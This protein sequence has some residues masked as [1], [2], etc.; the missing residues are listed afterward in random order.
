[1][2]GIAIALLKKFWP[3]MV[4]FALGAI[5]VGGLTW[6]IQGLRVTA[7]QQ[8]TTRVQQAFDKFALDTYNT[9]LKAEAKRLE[10]EQ[11]AKDNLK[12]VQADHEKQI[13]SI[14]A[15]AVD[16]Y[17]AAHR[18]RNDAGANSGGGTVQGDGASHQMD[19]GAAKECVP[20]EG[21]IAD[22]A[23]DAEKVQA[24]RAYC[25][26]NNCPIE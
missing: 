11:K 23:E 4:A 25:T 18:V 26:L 1:M 22:A 20:D 9:G 3:Y 6:K 2:D 16:K 12:K 10:D 21:F 7:E 14:R 17:I 13:P 8:K 5:L 19:D 15:G 24:W